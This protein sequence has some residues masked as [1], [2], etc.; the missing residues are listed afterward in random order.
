MHLSPVPT[1]VHDSFDWSPRQQRWVRLGPMSW[2]ARPR[3]IPPKL[4]DSS[5]GL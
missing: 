5:N 2:D 3:L 4:I 1:P